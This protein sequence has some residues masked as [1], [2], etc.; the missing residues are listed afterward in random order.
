MA[1]EIEFI[2]DDRF[3]GTKRKLQAM[4][5]KL[6]SSLKGMNCVVLQEKTG[7][8][9]LNFPKEY[10]KGKPSK[11]WRKK[12][13][14]SKNCKTQTWDEVMNKINKIQAPYYKKI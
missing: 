6:K 9:E 14:V 12:Y 3:N 8:R 2:T 13:I 11:Q 7:I 10:P 4:D 1:Y 5:R